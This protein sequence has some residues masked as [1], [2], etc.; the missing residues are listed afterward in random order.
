M[1]APARPQPS[2]GT[3]HVDVLIVGAGL[4]GIGAAVHLARDCPQK[5][6]AIWE[7]RDASGGTWD[8][9][10]YPGIRSDSDMFTLGYNF[11]PWTDNKA[12]ADGPSI[13]RY[14][15]ATAAEHAIDDKIAY[16]H[17]VIAA[18]WS[19]ADARW[20][21]TARLPDG[22]TDTIGC[23]FLFMC[24]GYYDYD[25]PHDP[26][27]AGRE[28]F[29]G[30]IV[31]PQFWPEDLDYAGQRVVVVGSGATAMTLVPEMAKTAGHVTMLQRSPTYVVSRPGEDAIANALRKVL[32]DRW[33]YAITRWKNV[34][35]GRFFFT[36]ARAKPAKVKATMT[37]WVADNI[38]AELAKKHF[39][40]RYN[41]WDQRVCLI[42]DGDLYAAI[43]AGRAS[44]VTDTIDRFEADGIRLAS[45]E[46]LPADIIVT[47][48]GLRL[49]VG[50]GAAFSLDGAPIDFSKTFNYRGVMFSGV[51]N[52]AITF[53]YTNA[54]WTL[55][56]DLTSEYIGRLLN[57]MDARG[58]RVAT[59][60]PD[61]AIAPEPMLDFTS[62]YVERAL[63]ILPKQGDR[64]PWKLNQNYFLDRKLLRKAPINDG[65]LR[66]SSPGV[67]APTKT[68]VENAA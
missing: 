23:S 46:L 3:R 1:N 43:N 4:S 65:V 20:T 17:K 29:A 59:P 68:P 61:G 5:S 27:F 2:T 55:K 58:A 34:L 31:H 53:G 47:A 19:T 18:D 28:D 42:P 37:K 11:R 63:A 56:A 36:R 12:I 25:N 66:F 49:Q 45:G 50:G 51:P 35:L 41:P 26:E 62:G 22:T 60:V 67:G 48:T 33:A 10:R 32:P 21:V 14:V 52:F 15:R 44:V 7:G 30:T 6:V 16:G 38:G 39:T 64:L 9:F 13:L 57:A 54:S 24:S 8:L 40:P